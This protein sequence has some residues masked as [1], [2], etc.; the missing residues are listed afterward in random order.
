MPLDL[1]SIFAR[2]RSIGSES[3]PIGIQHCIELYRIV[4]L[5]LEWPLEIAHQT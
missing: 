3:L 5:R 2:N 1:P 4:L